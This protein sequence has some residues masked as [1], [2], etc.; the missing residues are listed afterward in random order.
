[1]H[2]PLISKIRCLTPNKKSTAIRN[3][4]HLY[5]IATREGVDLQPLEKE[6]NSFEK[7]MKSAAENE[8]YIKYI[9][10]RPR[11]NG[12]F[13]NINTNDVNGICNYMKK[14][15][16]KRCI[17][18]GI[19]SL[20]QE[21]AEDLN[22]TNK[23]SW[24]KFIH[25]NLPDIGE[26]FGISNANLAWVAAFHNE[27]R[28]PHVHFMLWSE[29]KEQH[30]KPFISIPQQ[31]KCRELL[32]KQMFKQE[33]EQYARLKTDFRDLLTKSTKKD[34]KQEIDSLK[35]EVLGIPE[36]R[37]LSRINKQLLSDSTKKILELVEAV[38]SEGSLK[39]KYMPPEVKEKINSLVSTILS[40]YEIQDEYKKFFN[41]TEQMALT[42]SPTEKQR[43]VTLDKAR[44]DIDTRLGNIVLNSV[45][46]L[47]TNKDL[48]F[49][50][51]NQKSEIEIIDPVDS[52]DE[53]DSSGQEFDLTALPKIDYSEHS[54]SN[55]A[56]FINW[57]REF[58][59]AL[60]EL[61]A[62]SPDFDKAISLLDGEHRK[63][64][65]LATYEI[66]KIYERNL[67]GSDPELAATYYQEAL[68]G[69][70]TIYNS[71]QKQSNYAAYRLGKMYQYGQ[72]TDENIESAKS[73][74]EKADNNVYAQ[75]ALAKILMSEA[76]A[77]DDFSNKA[78]I[79][80]LL[81]SSSEKNNYAAFELGRIYHEGLFDTLN[82]DI[83]KKYYKQAFDGFSEML[84]KSEKNDDLLYRLGKM[85]QL[86]L[87]TEVDIEQAT[88]LFEKAA[89]LKN[90][91]ALYSL[92]KIYIQS[93]DEHLLK[94]AIEILEKLYKLTPENHLVS[95]ALGSAYSDPKAK[96]YDIFKAIK[97]L[98]HA[99]ELGND[100]AM[101]KLGNIYCRP[102]EKYP[103]LPVNIPLAISYLEK[104]AD[105]G[106]SLAMYSLGKIFS[107]TDLGHYD[108]R[109]A[110]E[111]L[112]RA[113]SLGNDFAMLKL[114][115]MYSDS[116]DKYPK[117]LA[118]IPLAI[119]YLEKSANMG[120]HQAMYSFGKLLSA[121]DTSHYDIHKAIDFLEQSA[122]LGNDFAM[123]KLGNIYLWGKGVSQ[124]KEKGIYWLDKSA[125]AGNEFAERSK[126][127]YETF[128]EEKATQQVFSLFGNLLRSLCY[129]NNKARNG[130]LYTDKG[131]KGNKKALRENAR[132]N[133]HKHSQTYEP[134][135]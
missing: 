58:K 36:F 116:K 112:E 11:S 7:N 106:N 1:M 74:Y 57:N 79:V 130:S 34:I 125:A 42:Y 3:Y 35:Q 59:A 48:Y 133:P 39:Y 107:A 37:T 18:R 68:S 56:V 61:Y 75:Y 83:S 135:V 97:F 100:F 69:F 122:Y 8:A 117:L 82:D 4:N 104:S 44:K 43:Q 76:K 86:G 85:H 108:I 77:N 29:A 105:L 120:N 89:A 114:G 111:H 132:R 93:N 21:D 55:D 123:L 67:A 63:G 47:R 52:I 110:I 45:K 81:K 131:I 2:K 118:N 15:S 134:E 20:S 6:L 88:L 101:L 17:F 84:I 25:E 54:L 24:A 124:N 127:A 41:Y 129:S 115:N 33:R 19:I 9:N 98:E 12:L 121:P 50:V 64:N 60:A 16:N 95:Y 51:I 66:G 78:H 71:N 109:K 99:A 80:N 90:T 65:I 72:G 62:D 10:E 30:I 102:A 113:A 28:H 94:K 92:S 38:P 27:Q 31:H 126:Q 73:W 46:E 5:Y 32:S 87:G 91:N 13:G 53:F 40:K 49:S 70:Y 26:T 96:S 22:F 23:E 128:E 14:I 103:E 119:S